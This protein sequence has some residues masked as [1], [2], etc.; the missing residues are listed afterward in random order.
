MKYPSTSIVFSSLSALLAIFLLCPVSYSQ[1]SQAIP[2][3]KKPI[4]PISQPDKQAD[5]DAPELS[6]QQTA[7]LYWLTDIL[8]EWKKTAELPASDL[9]TGVQTL[10]AAAETILRI[11]GTPEEKLK[12]ADILTLVCKRLDE[13]GTGVMESNQSDSQQQGKQI[14]DAMRHTLRVLQRLDQK[15]ARSLIEQM[16][17]SSSSDSQKISGSEFIENLQL[18]SEGSE[19]DPKPVSALAGKLLSSNM[20]DIFVRYLRELSDKNPELARLLYRQALVTISGSGPDAGRR[21]LILSA[22]AFYEPGVD[23]PVWSPPSDG[24]PGQVRLSGTCLYCGQGENGSFLFFPQP[25]LTAEL[26][27]GIQP[28]RQDY[29]SHVT[30][31]LISQLVAFSGQPPRNPQ[32]LCQLYF[33]TTKLAAY[34]SQ[35]ATSS[36]WQALAQEIE[37][38]AISFGLPQE[39]MREI[40]MQAERIAS[41]RPTHEI[42]ESKTLIEKSQETADDNQ[43]DGLLLEAVDALI[44]EGRFEEAERQLDRVKNKLWRE[45][46][47]EKLHLRA[48]LAATKEGAD[49][50]AREHLRKLDQPETRFLARL[51]I[52]RKLASDPAE[53]SRVRLFEII[54]AAEQEME[55]FR[56]E[57]ELIPAR[58]ALISL[59][60]GLNPSK[61]QMLAGEYVK[62]INQTSK[63]RGERLIV[64]TMFA[65][66]E[67]GRFA[68]DDSSLEF[69]FGQL[70][71]SD[72]RT[73]IDTARTIKSDLLRQRALLACAQKMTRSV[74]KQ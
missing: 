68:L 46:M 3:H 23:Y 36:Q 20:P 45:Q 24:K 29:L 67:S 61:A 65:G 71:K 25:A 28:Y 38:L 49:D 66:Q 32:L 62:A 37:P 54:L 70:A 59:L 11:N 13:R 19:K 33:L 6:A 10:C 2:P 74:Q 69:C 4:S 63:Y 5:T 48:V 9:A 34:S 60:A 58:G 21:A 57:P 1:R 55:R 7:A 17:Q 41:Q 43:R 14:R 26:R 8:N 52:A 51:A 12:L 64:K 50:L 39:T 18:V 72:W 73:A 47:A 56:R 31:N 22:I 30:P 16:L 35:I 42:L 44:D 53:E 15:T 40:K 27:A